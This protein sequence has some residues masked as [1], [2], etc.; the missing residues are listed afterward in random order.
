MLSNHV[1]KNVLPFIDFIDLYR[2]SEVQDFECMCMS[3]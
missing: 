1:S 3:H 2:P